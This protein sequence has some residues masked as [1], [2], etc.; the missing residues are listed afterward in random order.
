M[1]S[2]AGDTDF[3]DKIYKIL[4]STFSSLRALKCVRARAEILSIRFWEPAVRTL[5][6]RF[7]REMPDSRAGSMVCIRS[8]TGIPPS[9]RQVKKPHVGDHPTISQILVWAN[10]H[11]E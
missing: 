9:P 3:L 1:L 11:L 6:L 10:S 4:L 7:V 2:L 5:W 8:H